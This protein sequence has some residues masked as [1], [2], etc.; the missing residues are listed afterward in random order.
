MDVRV[1]VGLGT[2]LVEEKMVMLG[3]VADKQMALM[4]MGSPIVGNVELRNTLA[5][6][7]ELAGWKNSAEFWKPWGAAEEQQM[8]EQLAQQPPPPDPAQMIAE[9]EQM[10]A[11]AEAQAKAA[12][13]QLDQQKMFL[14]ADHAR[15]KL[16]R[17]TELKLLE[18]QAKY[19]AQITEAE[20]RDRSERERRILDADL[21]QL[22]A[23]AGSGGGNAGGQ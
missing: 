2:G 4:Q 6:I 1:N 15:D 20:L 21:A 16:A 22:S 14:E 12:K 3:T 13:A 7:T 9:A 17:E 5:R 8:Q 19:G 11:Q 18:I 23:L 10:K